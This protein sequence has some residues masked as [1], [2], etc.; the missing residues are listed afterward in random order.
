MNPTTRAFSSFANAR[1]FDLHLLQLI[2]KQ[3]SEQDFLDYVNEQFNP[4]PASES[5]AQASANALRQYVYQIHWTRAIDAF[6]R[7]IVDVLRDVLRCQPKIMSSSDSKLTYEDVFEA[8]DLDSLIS[9]MI[10]KTVNSMGGL[11]QMEAWFAKRKIPLKVTDQER[12]VLSEAVATRN[13]IVHNAA[14]VNQKYVKDFKWR[15]FNIG[16]RRGI[17]IDELFLVEALVRAVT[18]NTDAAIAAKFPG[19]VVAAK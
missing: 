2:N 12:K 1:Y 5:E 16:D 7:Y 15:G 8:P 13:L 4:P 14:I 18:T 3:L 19:T 10:E 6:L 11:K 9:F 17:G